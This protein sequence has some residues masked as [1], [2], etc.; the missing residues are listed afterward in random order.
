VILMSVLHLA[1]IEKPTTLQI[2]ARKAAFL[3]VVAPTMFL[4][5]LLY[6][7][8]NPVSDGVALV[9]IWMTAILFIVSLGDR[10]LDEVPE[11]ILTREIPRSAS[12]TNFRHW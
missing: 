12:R 5:V 8:G 4:G 7:A 9:A 10:S 2:R 11:E 1:G 3:S 6:M